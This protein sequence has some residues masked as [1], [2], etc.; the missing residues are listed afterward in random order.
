M[1]DTYEVNSS[2]SRNLK[3][4][5]F[6]L[7]GALV[8]LTYGDTPPT[9]MKLY[10]D[11]FKHIG[12][13]VGVKGLKQCFINLP[14]GLPS[15]AKIAE[16]GGKAFVKPVDSDDHARILASRT[17]SAV[18][19]YKTNTTAIK[20]QVG[21]LGLELVELLG[22]VHR[23]SESKSDIF[24]KLK[25]AKDYAEMVIKQNHGHPELKKI[26]EKPQP[27][28]H[29][30]LVKHYIENIVAV[31]DAQAGEP[32]SPELQGIL[33]RMSARRKEKKNTATVDDMK[34]GQ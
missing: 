22:G 11:A 19:K 10:L 5:F 26:L 13:D 14:R 32:L 16:L 17:L 34:K 30:G 24:Y 28:I 15:I 33:D 8:E 12:F 3:E 7:F 6:E 25:V 9:L 29:G 27:Y 20:T 1:F 18:E 2:K 23:I 4:E 21:E 31:N